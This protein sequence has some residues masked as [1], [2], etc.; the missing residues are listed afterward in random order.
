MTFYK[1]GQ[2]PIHKKYSFIGILAHSNYRLIIKL[3]T[4]LQ[5]TDN[6]SLSVELMFL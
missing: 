4:F 5:E 6:H 2:S 1:M 3:I